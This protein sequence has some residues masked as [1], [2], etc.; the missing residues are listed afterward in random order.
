MLLAAEGPFGRI[1]IS[2][3]GHR[4]AT[5]AL[6]GTLDQYIITG[7]ENGEIVQWDVKVYILLY[8]K[9]LF[10]FEFRHKKERV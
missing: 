6:W 5:S 3:A 1:N 10:E 9:L 7:H 2:D 8:L 4:K